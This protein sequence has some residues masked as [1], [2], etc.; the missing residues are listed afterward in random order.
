[1]LWLL[2]VL[3]LLSVAVMIERGLYY[4]SLRFDFAALAE[5]L[6]RM[7]LD[8]K[9]GDARKQAK[10]GKGPVAFVAQMGLEEAERGADAAESAMLGAKARVRLGL[11]RNLAFLGTLGSNAPFI[12]L[13]GTVLGI[14]K[15]FHDLAGNQA[16]GIQVVMSGIS[17]ALVATAVGLLVAIPAVVGFNVYN[18][19]VRAVSAQIDVVAQVILAALRAELTSHTG[20]MAKAASGGAAAVAASATKGGHAGKSDKADKDGETK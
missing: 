17:E 15:A 7:L 4:Y 1:V 13:F 14:I 9:F 5:D 3:S 12:G 20:E 11:E 18:R 19:R 6:R 16:G 10:A 2:I 8:G